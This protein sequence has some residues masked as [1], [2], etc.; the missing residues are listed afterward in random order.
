MYNRVCFVTVVGFGWW[1]LKSTEWINA[2]CNILIPNLNITNNKMNYIW[3][4]TCS[5][6][7]HFVYIKEQQFN[8]YKEF[9]E[10]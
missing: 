7:L 9:E 6:S 3:W 5:K 10:R 4:S 1:S 8:L 2:F